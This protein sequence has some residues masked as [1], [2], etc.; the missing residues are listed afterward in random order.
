MQKFIIILFLLCYI[1]H[2]FNIRVNSCEDDRDNVLV[3]AKT[4]SVSI[5]C[6]STF[7]LLKCS[8]SKVG[9]CEN[10]RGRKCK[11]GSLEIQDQSNSTNN[12]CQFELRNLDLSG[13]T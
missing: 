4:R 8:I 6:R 3:A 1:K 13:V 10:C 5:G 12:V 11:F 9:S 7:K 2:S